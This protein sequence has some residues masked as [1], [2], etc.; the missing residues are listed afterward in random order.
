VVAGA[1]VFVANGAPHM[2]SMNL[3][4]LL[5]P[6]VVEYAS[7]GKRVDVNSVF[8]FVRAVPMPAATARG[9]SRRGPSNGTSN[10]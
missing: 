5:P 4:A 3:K 1:L 7:R 9:V 6:V 2:F 10:A 8:P